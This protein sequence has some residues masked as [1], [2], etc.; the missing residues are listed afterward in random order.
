MKAL[1]LDTS[2]QGLTV[3]LVRIVEKQTKILKSYGSS[4]PQEAAARLPEICSR[5]LHEEGLTLSDIEAFMVSRGP[6]SFTG[7]KIG[8][9]FAQGLKQGMPKLR[10]YGVSAFA[11]LQRQLSH[12][13]SLFL[14]ATQTAGYFAFHTSEGV[15]FGIVDLTSETVLRSVDEAMIAYQV[16][17]PDALGEVRLI[18]PWPKLTSWLDL[19]QVSHESFAPESMHDSVITGMVED[20]IANSDKL[21]EGIL[22][23]IYLRKSAPEE[24]LEQSAKSLKQD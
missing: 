1:V 12:G 7:I 11:G 24:K 16:V 13:F 14:P 2:L 18:A 23:P 8:L 21:S 22:E 10:F 4:L 5:L 9:A 20:F 3:G 6:G 19:H 15:A 17:S